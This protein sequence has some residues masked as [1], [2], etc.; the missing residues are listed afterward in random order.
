MDGTGKVLYVVACGGY[1]A[2]R[3]DGFISTRQERGWDVCVI[4]TPSGLKFMDRIR[5]ETLTGH[6]VRHDYK[7]PDEPDVLPPADAIVVAPATFNTINKL[8]GGIS[9]T[10][11]LGVLHEAIGLGL[12]VVAVPTPNS[13][14][15]KHPVFGASVAALRS[16]GVQVLFDLEKYPMP[17]PRVGVADFFPWPALEAVMTEVEAALPG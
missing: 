10:L 3:L 2:G 16:W 13:A 6:V 9:D 1:V 14:L 8:A 5:M 4:A 15:A 11:A 17:P 7:Q 12:P